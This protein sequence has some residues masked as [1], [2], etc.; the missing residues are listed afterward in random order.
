MKPLDKKG[1][2]FSTRCLGWATYSRFK[3]LREFAWMLIGPTGYVFSP[4]DSAV[5][6]LVGGDV[7]FA[8]EPRSPHDVGVYRVRGE[9]ARHGVL[10]RIRHILWAILCRLCF[11]PRFFT[12][13]I[14]NASF[15]ELLVKS[16]ENEK[17]RFARHDDRIYFNIDCSST[18][19]K[20]AYPFEKIA[21]LMKSRH[22]VLVNLETPLTRHPR[23]RGLFSSDP[24]Y[25]QAMKDAGISLVSL[26]NNHV[27]DVGETGFLQTLDHLED[28]GISYT[29]AG[30]NFEDARLGKLLQIDGTELIF[31]NYTQFCNSGFA[32]IAAEYPG[33][34]PLDPE[35]IV[36]DVRVARERAAL[37]FVLLH[38]GFE[39]QPNVHPKQT[40]I[41][42][43]LINAGADAIIGHHPHVPHGIEVY[44][45]RPILYSLGNFVFGYARK[46]WS[47]NYLAEIVIDQERIHGIII[48]PISGQ[49]QGLFRPEVLSGARADA[50]LHELQIKSAIF[51]TAIA[52][53]DHIGYVRIQ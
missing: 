31:L 23:V 21:P 15:R 27:F 36:E 49:G 18:T 37:V 2:V 7:S 6:I 50:L 44:K 17:R 48:Y 34:L 13:K 38:W 11:S 14:A 3:L 22:L 29:G 9:K 46:E 30:S 5:R 42:H 26:A 8:F 12:A 47:D 16:P 40:E 51:D 19:S 1:E 10:A 53:Q 35:L 32:S 25:A 52:I 28:A 33:I 39:N 20:F 45:E 24:R 41:A 4:S 43:L